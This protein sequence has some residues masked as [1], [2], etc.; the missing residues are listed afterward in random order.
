M[1]VSLYEANGG[2]VGGRCWTARGFAGGQTAEHGG[3]FI[4][5]RHVHLRRLVR[6]LGLKLDDGEKIPESKGEPVLYLR[7]KIRD[8]RVV[9][10][11]LPTVLKRLERDTK[12]IGPYTSAKAGPA[13]RAFDGLSVRDWLDR[14]V[15]GGAGS[16]LHT[17]L[18]DQITGFWGGDP[19]DLSAIN[20]I[21]QFTAPYEGA[22]ERWH[23]RG[24]ND[25]VPNLLARRLPKGVLRMNAPLTAVRRNGAR[26][27]L[28]FGHSSRPVFADRV[29]FALPFTALRQV[30]L[31]GSGLS[32]RK[33]DVIDNLGMG[34][35]A[36]LLLQFDDRFAEH[37]WDGTFSSDIPRLGSWSSSGGHP[38]KKDL[39]TIFSGGAAGAN[40]PTARAHGKAPAH[41]VKDALRLI[42][43]LVP[44]MS[45]AYN[46]R[47]WLDSWVDDPWARGS[48]ATFRPGQY[49]RYW[50]AAG[51]AEGCLHFAGEHTS[52]HSQGYLN[53]G[54][55]SGERAAREV[56]KA[57]GR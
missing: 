46:G 8:P 22:D 40:Y 26:Y 23:V 41:V 34:T 5:T 27:E 16:L 39:L 35:N 55:E 47:S 57:L 15:P 43:R 10:K 14:N 25:R 28:R 31:D 51:D 6:E 48:Y 3:E 37:G 9:F 56:L 49:T 42:E 13:A 11:D 30:D 52:V 24:G 32:A 50:G 45:A 20:L 4:D 2:R 19:E 38:A 44:G 53:G 18:A 54:V 17:A 7:G 33:R 1:H 29:I 12:R 36:K 21:E